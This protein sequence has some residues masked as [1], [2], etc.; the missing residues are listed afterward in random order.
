M[1]NSACV[2]ADPYFG[3]KIAEYC[4]KYGKKYVT[5]D[6]AYDSYIHEHCAVNCISHQHLDEYYPDKSYDELFSLYTDNTEGLVIFTLGEKGAMYGR[7]GA[8]PKMC[9]AFKVDVVSTLGAGDSFKAGAVYGLYKGLDDD[10]SVSY[11]HLT[12][13]TT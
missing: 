4:V 7:K 1:K 12:L 8:V 3:D 6:C 2:A 10:T 11:T 9:P 5:I 13:P